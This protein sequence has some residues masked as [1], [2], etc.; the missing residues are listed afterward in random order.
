MSSPLAIKTD[1]SLG[2]DETVEIYFHTSEGSRAGGVTLYFTPS[3]KYELHKCTDSMT[4]FSADLPT[5]KEKV[6]RISLTKTS[7]IG[8]VIHCND[9]EVLD[10]LM[11]DSACSYNRWDNHWGKD[12]EKIRFDNDDTAS[13]YFTGK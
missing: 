12:V 1:S 6:W 3:P 8:L 11:S 9:E 2:S 5:E 10:L 4:D 7:G 13:D